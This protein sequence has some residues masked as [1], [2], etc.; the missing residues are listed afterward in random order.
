MEIVA[1]SQRDERWAGQQLGEGKLTI[2]QAGCLLS[3]VASLLA[4]WGQ[5]TDPGRLNDFVQ[6]SYGFVDGNL[7]VFA[8]VDGLAC[9]FVEFVDCETVP[10]PV[11]K[12]QAAVASGRGVVCCVDATPG[13]PVDKHWVWLYAVGEAAQSAGWQ[14]VDPWRRPGY[15]RIDLGS[16]LASGWD[17]ARGIFAAAIYERLQGRTALAWRSD[18]EAHQS[19]VC[20]RR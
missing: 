18:V 19:A 5:D 14:I 17:V 4:S 8:S 15:E 7:F 13:G 2:G 20:V 11:A 3:A 16:Y 10:A 9:R 1:F 6:R 12:L